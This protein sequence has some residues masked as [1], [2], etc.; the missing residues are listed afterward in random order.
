MTFISLFEQE[1]LDLA[2]R[3]YSVNHVD[4]AVW[5]Q[6]V[7][8][9]LI[10]QKEGAMDYPQLIAELEADLHMY[11]RQAT[12]VK[13]ALFQARS[14][15]AMN[16]QGYKTFVDCDSLEAWILASDASTIGDTNA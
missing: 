5:T 6:D 10:E 1:A 2:V 9:T 8:L 16:D 4:R 11:E 12:E 3:N 14:D 15:M 13:D 7:E